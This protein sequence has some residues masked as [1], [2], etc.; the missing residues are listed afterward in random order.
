MA[1]VID[2][3]EEG[4][5]PGVPN[6]RITTTWRRGRENYHSFSFRRLDLN[7]ATS[8]LPICRCKVQLQLLLM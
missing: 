7:V 5:L 8:E 1:A 3:V 6:V 2:V 4:A